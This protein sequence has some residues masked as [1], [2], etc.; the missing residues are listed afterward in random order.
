MADLRIQFAAPYQC[1]VFELV[2][3]QDLKL[4]VATLAILLQVLRYIFVSDVVFLQDATGSQQPYIIAARDQI[5]QI[6]SDLKQA[7]QYRLDSD[8][9]FRLISFRDH[10]PQDRSFI[11]DP[12]DFTSDVTVLQGQLQRLFATGGGDGPEAQADALDA[13]LNSAWRT[14]AAK[15]VILITDSPPHGVEDRGDGFPDG[16][17]NRK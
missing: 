17:P 10:P 11:I 14:D 13:A 6:C 16:S 3:D 9:R 15:V 7:G 12:H 4:C 8:L 5:S 2:E 1:F